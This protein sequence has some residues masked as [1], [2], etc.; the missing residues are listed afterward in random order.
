MNRGLIQRQSDNKKHQKPVALLKHTNSANSSESES[1]AS[2]MHS[3]ASMDSQRSVY[4]HAT[5]VADIP[6]AVLVS[7]RRRGPQAGASREDVSKMSGDSALSG[8]P[9]TGSVERPTTRRTSR[10]VSRSYSMLAPWK[11]RHYRDKFQISYSNDQ[12]QQQQQKQASPPPAA[13]NGDMGKPPRPPRRREDAAPVI[14]PADSMTA[15]PFRSSVARSSTV[16]SSA[17]PKD[18]KLAGWFRKKKR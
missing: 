1:Q 9:A 16:P 6:P 4:L 7:Q 12:Q 11:P 5:T 17:M 13:V 15:S 18:S 10:H 14:D 8:A 3:G 2:N